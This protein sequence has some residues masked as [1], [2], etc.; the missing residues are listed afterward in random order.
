MRKLCAWKG[1]NIPKAEAY[2]DHVHMLVEISQKINVLSFYIEKTAHLMH[3]S[4]NLLAL[5]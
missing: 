3:S 4:K 1:I 2:P 5:K